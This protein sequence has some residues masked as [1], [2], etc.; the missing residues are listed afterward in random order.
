MFNI[1]PTP[2][3]KNDG[4]HGLTDKSAGMFVYWTELKHYRPP[5]MFKRNKRA[6]RTSDVTIIIFPDTPLITYESVPVFQIL[7]QVWD[8]ITEL[9]YSYETAEHL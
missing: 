8:V 6:G 1:R 9:E 7:K 3:T 2:V 4:L 5:T